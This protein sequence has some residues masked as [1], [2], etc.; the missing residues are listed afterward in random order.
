MR[1]EEPR[2]ELLTALLLHADKRPCFDSSGTT[3]HGKSEFDAATSVN[4]RRS[5]QREQLHALR[6]EVSA[7]GRHLQ[8]LSESKELQLSLD[9]L[10]NESTVSAMSWRGAATRERHARANAEENKA[11]LMRRISMNMSFLE[12]VKQLLLT[13]A[14]REIIGRPSLCLPIRGEPIALHNEDL[15]VY[16]ALQSSLDH[17]C[18]QLDAILQQCGSFRCETTEDKHEICIHANGRGVEVREI[19]VRPFGTATIVDAM[20]QHV[21]S[22]ANACWHKDGDIVRV[23]TDTFCMMMRDQCMLTLALCVCLVRQA[24]SGAGRVLLGR[25]TAQCAQSQCDEAARSPKP[26][27]HALGIS[28]RV[29]H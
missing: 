19:D 3:V 7:L 29:R 24:D 4:S 14:A 8:Q 18:H 9:R 20:Q 6:Q 15:Q 12:N 13:Q 17:R 21:E 16:Q 5:T 1:F 27:D 2:D 11:E 22:Q 25:K 26:D 23:P 10:L 28:H